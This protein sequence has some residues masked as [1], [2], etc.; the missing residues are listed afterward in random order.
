MSRNSGARGF[1]KSKLI[2]ILALIVTVLYLSNDF[3]I[4]DIRQTA[5]IAAI[6]L[7]KSDGMYEVSVQI[8]IPQA[9]DQTA[10]NSSAVL[11]GRGKTVGD[12]LEQIGTS[13]GWYI[14]LS[15]C[16]LI[17][18]GE[19]LFDGD[20]MQPLDY[21]LRTDKI[22]DTARLCMAEKSAKD[23]LSAKTPLDELSAFSVTKILEPD[24]ESLSSIAATSV[25]EFAMGYYSESGFSSMPIVKLTEAEGDNGGGN[26]ASSSVDDKNEVNSRLVRCDL[27]NNADNAETSYASESGGGKEKSS[28]E[29]S[30]IFD[31]TSTVLLDKGVKKLV[32]EKDET[33]AFNMMTHPISEVSVEVPNVE[34]EGQN[35]TV[36]LT[37]KNIK[38]SI[39]LRFMGANPILELTL[40][41][42]ARLDDADVIS[43]PGGLVK[44]YIVPDAV[45]TKLSEFFKN[46]IES[47]FEKSRNVQTD[48]FQVKNRLYRTQNKYFENMKNNILKDVKI[49]VKVKAKSYR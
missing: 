21:F 39:K 42:D 32:L 16:N 25:K 7:D 46:K 34:Y 22:Q 45:L 23:I 17:I 43:D 8:A 9:T 24:S 44:N 28:N 5:L 48:I 1:I 31:A 33:L 27:R 14:K 26:S 18:L 35:T 49:S 4:I 40:A 15:F 2:L 6:G 11:T 29:I 41:T 36:F 47:V 20:I 19:S 37:V 3:S 30:N 10:S 13:T 12:A 38:K